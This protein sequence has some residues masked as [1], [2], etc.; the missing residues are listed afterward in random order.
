MKWRL[1]SLLL[2]VVITNTTNT[3]VIINSNVVATKEEVKQA[4]LG[5]KKLW[6]NGLP[7]IIFVLPINHIAT[8]LF[9]QNVLGITSISLF[10]MYDTMQDCHNKI[11][12]VLT[13]AKMIISV[14]TTIGAIGYISNSIIIQDNNQFIKVIRY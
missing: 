1:A 10:N 7:V 3:E 14:A 8:K 5:K 9:A 4:F 2:L 12:E 6:N 13:E 11:I